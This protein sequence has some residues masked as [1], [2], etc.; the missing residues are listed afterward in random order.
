MSDKKIRIDV[1]STGGKY[2]AHLPDT[3]I[4]HR[5]PVKI[6][7]K[8]PFP[9]DDT[10]DDDKWA[11][12]GAKDNLPT[13]IRQQ[14]EKVPVAYA[15]VYKLVSMMYGNGIAYYQNDDLR[16]GETKIKR[17]YN[18][19]V[20]DWLNINYIR[21]RYLSAQFTDY[22][23]YMNTFSEF[24]LSKDK[25]LITNLYSKPAEFCRLE[26][27]HERNLN[28]EFLYYSPDFGSDTTPTANRMKK[29]PL[30]IWYEQADFLA[31]LKKHKFAWH[32]KFETPSITYYAKAFWNGLFRENGWIDA[33]I[34]VP[35]VVNSMMQNQ[36]VLKYQI[37]IPET[38][39]QI[40]YQDWDTYT[41]KQRDEAIDKV[42]NEINDSLVGTENAFTSI[43]TVFRE[44]Q[45]TGAALGKLEIIA[46]DDKLKK[47]SWVPSSTIADAQIVQ[48]LGLHPSQMGLSNEGGK[49]GAGSGSDQRESFNT[50]ITLNTI[51]QRIALSALN[52]AARYNAMG[53]NF[54]KA[55]VVNKDWDITFFI[56]HTSHTTTNNQE[57]GLVES[58]TTLQIGA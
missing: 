12:W 13:L 1:S 22:R 25:K 16:R 44:D 34:A 35:E 36:I 5:G 15:T 55:K 18:E 19:T 3:K 14:L 47:D 32:S 10:G 52:F 30:F 7:T 27:Q 43:T 53:G 40:R 46:I 2:T 20:E 9:K 8:A 33:A 11:S 38:Y 29:I 42:V 58:D 45:V 54:E 6:I 26:K 4:S 56:D 50:E 48:G 41:D 37:L 28:I 39:F 51:D 23:M 49:M 57:S 31:K 17:A 24:V 21:D